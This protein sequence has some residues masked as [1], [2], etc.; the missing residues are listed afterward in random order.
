MEKAI[1]HRKPR[2]SVEPTANDTAN[3]LHGGIN[4]L[5]FC[6]T[7]RS[8]SHSRKARSTQHDAHSH[9]SVVIASSSIHIDRA[10]FISSVPASAADPALVCRETAKSS[11][12]K[13][14]LIYDNHC[15]HEVTPKLASNDDAA[16][17][18]LCGASSDAIS[19][20]KTNFTSSSR[21]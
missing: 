18:K 16:I 11:R 17:I 1:F 6:L 2:E 9:P 14:L 19:G 10:K 21:R 8:V 12:W 3:S 4:T 13:M 20:G 15:M 5:M 7:A